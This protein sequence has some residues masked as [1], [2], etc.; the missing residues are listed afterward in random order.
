MLPKSTPC[1]DCNDSHGTPKPF[2]GGENSSVNLKIADR[3]RLTGRYPT[4]W[5]EVRQVASRHSVCLS[6]RYKCVFFVGVIVMK[7]IA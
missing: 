1:Y 3:N 2:V 5:C 7:V 6:E 4:S